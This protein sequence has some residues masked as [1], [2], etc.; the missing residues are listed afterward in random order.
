MKKIIIFFIILCMTVNITLPAFADSIPLSNNEIA[1]QCENIT[2]TNI[3]EELDDIIQKLFLD[4]TKF[5]LEKIV[6]KQWKVLNIDSTIDFEIDR[7]IKIVDNNTG[8]GEKFKGSWSSSK[9]EKLTREVTDLTFNSK[10]F[11]NKLELLSLNVA[12]EIATELELVSIGS[13]S[14]A[15]GCLERYIGRQYSEAV[16]EEFNKE[17]YSLMPDSS[18]SIE[19]LPP[20]NAFLIK[21]HRLAIGGSAIIA[22]KIIVQKAIS[23]KIAQRISQRIAGRVAGRIGT[24]LIPVIDIAS[25]VLLIGDLVTSFDG[26][27]PEIRSNLKSEKVKRQLREEIA[28]NLN[29]EIRNESL[30]IPREISNEIY[31]QWLNFQKNYHETLALI[32]DVPELNEIYSKTNDKSK[33]YSLIGILSNNIGRKQIIATIQ[34]GSFTELLSLPEVTYKMLQ[35]T[36]DPSILIEWNNLAGNQIENVV[37]L[38]IYKHLSPQK[39]NRQMLKDIL[40]VK[41]YKTISKLSLLE[42][43]SIR[44]LLGISIPN[45]IKLANLLSAEELQLLSGYIT[46]LEQPQVNKFIRFLLDENTSIIA[47]GDVV[48]HLVKSKNIDAAI[49]LWQESDDIFSLILNIPFLL[50]KSISWGL[51]IIKYGWNYLIGLLLSTVLI[52]VFLVVLAFSLIRRWTNKNTNQEQQEITTILN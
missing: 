46:D 36:S 43:E 45:L 37:N 9:A 35:T 32:A 22:S 47:N 29:E 1:F 23:K 19:S 5:N 39:L 7:A 17:I 42:I 25:G 51:F 16:V 20:D 50:N 44:N 49:R 30:Q 48:R 26:G 33:I 27:L 14:Y 28:N 3:Q 8:L 40:A 21:Q 13:S 31:S 4:K 6:T 18:E 41:D 15:M 24:G 52:V 11:N 38:E 2:N 12:D 10:K 34:D